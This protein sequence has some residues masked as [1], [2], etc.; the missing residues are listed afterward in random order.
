LGEVTQEEMID[1]FGIPD[2][3]AALGDKTYASVSNRERWPV[4]FRRRKKE[5]VRA[6]AK[7]A[8][9]CRFALDASL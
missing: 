1:A 5:L 6:I 4:I 8:I 2:K 9:A 3:T 7:I